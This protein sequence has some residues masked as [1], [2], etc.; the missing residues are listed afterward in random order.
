R[1]LT[2]PAMRTVIAADRRV[3]CTRHHRRHHARAERRRTA[4][5]PL[6]ARPRRS[7][8]RR[9]R[10]PSLFL[11]AGAGARRDRTNRRSPSFPRPTHR[12]GQPLG[13]YAEEI[14]PST[15]RHLGN[16]PQAI[17]HAAFLQAVLALR[18]QS[19]P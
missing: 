15:S 10:V 2:E 6:S 12:T 18:D 14:D 1:L 11:L 4:A 7:A 8:W 13:L 17:T 3:Q 5:L 16:Y 9:G 19:Q